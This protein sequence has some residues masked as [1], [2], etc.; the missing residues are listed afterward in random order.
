MDFFLVK[1]A[2]ISEIMFVQS[3]KIE[4]KENLTKVKAAAL[5]KHSEGW[6]SGIVV[7]FACSTLAAWG[8]PPVWILGTDLH[9]AH[10]T[11]LWQHP[12]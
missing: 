2:L 4:A 10:Q 1:S 7:K 6:P 11:V 3:F 9:M 5:K 8:S 12:A